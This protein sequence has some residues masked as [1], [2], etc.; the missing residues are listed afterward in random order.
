LFYYSIEEPVPQFDL[1]DDRFG[2]AMPAAVTTAMEI[3]R[4]DNRTFFRA[5]SEEREQQSLK[6][7]RLLY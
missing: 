2:E 4:P 7:E 6:G 3:D 5:A 1:I